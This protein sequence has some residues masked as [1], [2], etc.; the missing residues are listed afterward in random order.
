MIRREATDLAGLALVSTLTLSYEVVQTRVFSFS[1][2]PVIAFTAIAIAMTGFG[3]GATLL[4]LVPS[5][6][7]DRSRRTLPLASLGLLAAILV[8][9][10]WFARTSTN[11]V[12]D[13]IFSKNV[14]WSSA[15]SPVWSTI[16][17]LPCIVPYFLSG[18]VTAI[19]LSRGIE[20]IGRVYFVNLAG[21]AL[22]CVVAM[23]LLRPLGAPGLVVFT[24]ALAGGAALTFS[25][26]DAGPVRWASG[27]AALACGILVPF[28]QT[29]MPFQA[30]NNEAI[31]KL[32]RLDAAAGRPPPV[33]E[34][35]E[36]DPLARIDVV[37]HGPEE[38]FIPEPLRYRSVT[39]DGGAITLL[40]EDP[41]E[42]GWGKGLFEQSMYSVPYH[43]RESPD[44][45]VIGLGG[46]TDVNTALHWNARSVTAA[47]ISKGTLHAVTGPYREF[48]GFPDHP[49]VDLV[50]TDG[51]SYTKSTDRRFDVIQL[52][53]V[54]TITVQSSGSM[55][56]AEDY[57]YTTEAFVDF[58]SVLK[59]EG[60]LSVMRFGEEGISLAAIAA[61]ALR[62]MGVDRPDRNIVSLRQK[63]M[64]G[65]LAKKTPFTDEEIAT[66][67]GLERWSR[68]ETVLVPHYDV[69]GLT[70]GAPLR[71]LHPPGRRPDA[72]YGAFFDAMS[73][74]REKE[75]LADLGVPFIV[76]TDDRPYYMM[77]YWLKVLAQKHPDNP[78]PHLFIVTSSITAAAA[79][80]FMLVPVAWVRRRTRPGAGAMTSTIV[81]FFAL[82][83]GF[84]IL[85]VGLIHRTIV[86][87]GTPGSAVSVVLAS[88][89]VSSG[90]GSLV[91]ETVPWS[92]R[93]KLVAALLGLLAVGT[94]MALGASYILEP[95]FALPVHAR[96]ALAALLLAPAGFC[97]GWF[98]P[99]GLAVISRRSGS[100]VPW[101][102]AV[103]GFASVIGSLS[104]VPVGMALGFSAMFFVAMGLYVIAVATIVALA[105]H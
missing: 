54:D 38:I 77:G 4:S 73:Q 33:H 75:A 1:L 105:R 64:C 60:V 17:L 42:E 78:L 16:V 24:A 13:E 3:L 74:G 28:G 94:T 14:V 39:I 84:M 86:F 90:L 36:W 89:L 41:G 83:A 51:R 62:R 45:L 48:A 87:V 46:G 2:H 91:S 99:T 68:R 69:V 10:A 59:P 88:I 79:F 53:G 57:L 21:S 66:V 76:P 9:N 23:A 29:V 32:E 8:V 20:R 5:L 81:Y 85:E 52:S 22:G 98:F 11:V 19:V 71:F 97:M 31:R 43:L 50:H 40:I 67:H 27:A 26:A 101:A 34:F 15:V 65:I 70:L 35:T 96:E 25:L 7:A 93:S 103:N 55:I 18:L 80:L 30:D 6:A 100:L 104:V 61:S 47:E 92:P 44:V 56:L 49:A 37:K 63:M 72:R 95:L 58:F 102:I 82:G 12:A